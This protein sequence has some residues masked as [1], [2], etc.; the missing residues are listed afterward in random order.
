VTIDTGSLESKIKAKN[1][2]QDA[3]ISSAVDEIINKFD[4]NKASE[5]YVSKALKYQEVSLYENELV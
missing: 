2:D 4:V 5:Q 3:S 1:R